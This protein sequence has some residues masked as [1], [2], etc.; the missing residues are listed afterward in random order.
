V[1]LTTAAPRW[2]IAMWTSHTHLAWINMTTNEQIN[3]ERFVISTTSS[4]AGAAVSCQHLRARPSR[5][6][7]TLTGSLWRRRRFPHFRDP[8]TGKFFNPFDQGWRH[9]VRM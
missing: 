2:Q 6:A 4:C 3:H 5:D 9:N 1:W 7:G 8:V